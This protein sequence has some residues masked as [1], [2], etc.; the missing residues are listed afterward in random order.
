MVI[1][2]GLKRHKRR[3]RSKLKKR[4]KN[5]ITSGWK[6]EKDSKRKTLP[7]KAP[8]SISI[9]KNDSKKFLRF[10]RDIR[11]ATL[12]NRKRVNINFSE[13]TFMGSS[14]TL[15]LIAEIE[16]IQTLSKKN[17]IQGNLPKDSIAAQVFCKTGLSKLLGISD[18][19]EAEHSSVTYWNNYLTGKDGTVV[20]AAKELKRINLKRKYRQA[21][22]TGISEAITNISMH[23]YDDINVRDDG[24]GF[25]DNRWWMFTGFDDERVSLVICDIGKGIPVALKDRDDYSSLNKFIGGLTGVRESRSIKAAMEV[26]NSSSELSH[27]GKGM[28]QLKQAID[29]MN[30]GSLYIHSNKGYYK[31]SADGQEEYTKDLKYSVMGTIVSWS[32]P[33]DKLQKM[34]ENEQKND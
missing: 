33:L 1:K 25:I 8:Q 27:R 23:A 26:G 13:T 16:R 20:E 10:L 30:A 34:I 28:V 15:L 3:L 12:K 24:Y 5:R 29:I 32:A 9:F 6:N 21:F 18:K 31:Y 19:V 11:N 2:I 17:V 4:N 22:F 7:L 14:G